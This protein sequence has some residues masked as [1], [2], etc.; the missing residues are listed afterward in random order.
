M[1][2][3]GTSKGRCIELS[4]YNRT[5]YAKDKNVMTLSERIGELV[6]I[7]IIA[8]VTAFFAFHLLTNTGFMTS[9]FGL[10]GTIFLF[11]SAVLSIITSIARFITGR[12]DESRPFELVS[13]IYWT[14]ASIWFLSVFPFNFVHL[15]DP[16]PVYLKF[17]ISWISNDI[18][19]FI[20]LISFIGGMAASINAAVRIALGR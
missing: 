5:W 9:K 13:A 7:P 1:L 18:G 6:G 2:K 20:L 17:F 3:A 12:R 4:K 19:W 14:M 10:T 15:A 8:L 11:G 16:L